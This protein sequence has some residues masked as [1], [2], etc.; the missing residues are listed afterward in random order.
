MNS[1]IFI[2]SDLEKKNKNNSSDCVVGDVFIHYHDIITF[3][4]IEKYKFITKS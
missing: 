2:T 3:S 4:A 1:W